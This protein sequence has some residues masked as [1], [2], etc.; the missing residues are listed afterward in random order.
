[1]LSDVLFDAAWSPRRPSL[2]WVRSLLPAVR[3]YASDSVDESDTTRAVI[4]TAALTVAAVQ[5]V[6]GV[7]LHDEQVMA[8]IAMCAGW[9]VQMRTGEGK[10]FAAIHPTLCFGRLGAGVHVM[11]ANDYLA[12]RDAE[13]AGAVLRTL[14]LSVGVTA[15]GMTRP[16]VRAAYAADV[17]YG[18]ER[19]F[20]FD[21]L[22]D[23]LWLPG[24]M[25]V[26]RGRVVALV[27]EAD[28]V[29][30]DQARTPLVLSA[31][32]AAAATLVHRADAVV[33]SLRPEHI[34]VD[35]R[36]RTAQL[37]DGGIT[38][39]EDAL[40]VADLFT[41]A[42]D[43]P[44]RLDMALRARVLLARD[45]DYVVRD[46]RIHV[47]D[48]LTGRIVPGR[49]WGDGLHQALEAKEG[50]SLTDER[51]DIARISIGSY[52]AGYRRV[53]GMSGTLEAAEGELAD[54]VNMRVLT[55]PTHRPVIRVDQDD[56]A[57]ADRETK[58]AA[59]ADDVAARHAAGQ[60][61]LIGTRSIQ[62]SWAFS[63]ELE[64]RGIR[65]EVL[66]AEHPE[67]EAAIIAT[68]GRAG[69]VTVATQM[70]GRG[71]D[72][73]LEGDGAGLMVWGLGHHPNRRL[74]QQ[75]RGRAGRQGDPG[76]SR[77]AT[78]PDD[79]VPADDQAAV[80]FYEAATRAELR[81]F[82]PAHDRMRDVV[83]EWRRRARGGDLVALLD[84][85]VATT[86]N[87]ARRRR[88][89]AAVEEGRRSLQAR[90]CHFD[91]HFD[92]VARFTLGHLLVLRW[93]DLLAGLDLFERF[94]LLGPGHAGRVARWDAA[95][96]AHFADFVVRTK[97]EWLGQLHEMQITRGPAPIPS[98]LH[99]HARDEAAPDEVEVTIGGHDT[100]GARVMNW[101]RRV[102]GTLD[103]WEP[104]IVLNLE[105]LGDTPP[106]GN[107][108][109][110]LDL[111][112]PANSVAYI[113]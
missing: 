73:Q 102:Y 71:V 46:G 106:G 72:I 18:A 55:I 29:L 95:A 59:V 68:A 100:V 77:F 44:H 6:L 17:T 97:A 31:P 82:A 108:T 49:Q 2:D 80:E 75:L 85:A 20:G 38:A 5:R 9:G 37:S 42:T 88:R 60:P 4:S 105:A 87:E 89:R 24:D 53:L 62:E 28:A 70:A 40:G 76:M 57:F 63:S 11:T 13:W 43:W 109:I 10:T 98:D 112:D 22:R 92:E 48:E 66:S 36:T 14:G 93:A 84:D 110:H 51:R 103:A 69:A 19:D 101:I 86:T 74:D 26:Q 58:H 79:D 99:V 35:A 90:A 15:P 78:A 27:D 8:G 104:P 52:V 111:E 34:E 56:V 45:H 1:M 81:R 39:C 21:Y 33:R 25:P 65:H 94:H 3:A 23:G 96:G 113:P 83:V 7:E 41:E 16:E 64:A 67:R 54:A 32:T 91:G 61:V 47:V 12:R 50:L 30:L 107:V